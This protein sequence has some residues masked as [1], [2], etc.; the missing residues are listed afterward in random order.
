VEEGTEMRRGVATSI[1]RSDSLD[2]YLW[3]YLKS[4]VQK[5]KPENIQGSE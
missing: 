2:Y 4:K 3:G 1:I 5:I